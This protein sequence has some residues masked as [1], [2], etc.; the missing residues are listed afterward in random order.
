MASRGL[1][2]LLN[3][4]LFGGALAAGCFFAYSLI[5]NFALNPVDPAAEEQSF[6]VE[7]GWGLSKIASELESRK[8]INNKLSL[9]L[10]SQFMKG[11]DGKKLSEAKI[12]PGEYKMSP[13]QTP[14]ELLT[15]LAE[16]NIVY[17]EFNIPEGVTLKDI[18]KKMAATTLC[19]EEEA[20]KQFKSPV[21][22]DQFDIPALSVEGYVYPS[23]YKFT[24][25]DN[26][27]VMVERMIREGLKHKN[28]DNERR[29]NELNMTWHN[30]L[31]LA[32]IV[33]KETGQASERKI[34]SSV[35]HN[36][37]SIQMPLQTDPTVIYGIPNFDGN[38]TK[39]HLK[40]PGP[41]NT[42]LNTGL[43][44]TPIASPG[45][46]AIDA[47]LYPADTEYLFFVSKN[48]GSH[49]F[50]VTYAEHT[51]AMNKY[52]RGKKVA[53]PVVKKK[54]KKK[55]KKKIKEVVQEKKEPVVKKIK[56]KRKGPISQLDF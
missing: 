26:A 19:T 20:L 56:K 55:V 24:R 35:F 22:T 39:E 48:D 17:H 2:N 23:T 42:Y 32:S 45:K 11:P 46:D 47:A 29:A 36:R 1:S 5:G 54:K 52:Q 3:F 49:Q 27:R 53:A 37:M 4:I 18:A 9:S 31:T 50:S 33:E 13:A 12:Y 44:P 38:I 28:E 14:K 15:N 30:V 51:K 7:P 34:I 25:P 40:T 6:I 43:P 10:L 8:I 41:Y 21:V 16:A